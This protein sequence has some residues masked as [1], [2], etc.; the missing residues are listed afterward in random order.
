M[1]I[2]EQRDAY[3]REVDAL[4]N[5]M[6][7]LLSYVASEKFHADPTVQ[8]SDVAL[9]LM[10]VFGAGRDAFFNREENKETS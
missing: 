3:K 9:R 8:T 4:R 5:G 1:R 6:R 10:E 7:D 2:N